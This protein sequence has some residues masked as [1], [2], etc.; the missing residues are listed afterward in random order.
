MNTEVRLVQTPKELEEC[1]E[2][3][4]KVFIEEQKVTY[5]EEFDEFDSALNTR[6]FT[7]KVEAKTIGTCR[8]RKAKDGFKI[9]R[10]ALLKD[11]RKHGYGTRLM[12]FV[13]NY[14]KDLKAKR[15]YLYAQEEVIPF[16]EKLGFSTYGESFLDARIP[17]RAME[18]VLE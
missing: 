12:E 7:L 9:E 3:R 8:L 10:V 6:H 14:C 16:Y 15:I 5:E 18:L 17:H 4:K 11:Y 2:I 1:F 13:I